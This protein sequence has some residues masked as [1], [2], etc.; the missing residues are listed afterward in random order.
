[1][2]IVLPLLVLS[3]AMPPIL[4]PFAP[5]TYAAIAAQAGAYDGVQ[6]NYETDPAP[7]VLGKYTCEVRHWMGQMQL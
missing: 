7:A 6:Y 4:A 5:S 2:A 1:M 3:L